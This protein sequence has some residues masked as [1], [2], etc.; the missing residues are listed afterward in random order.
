MMALALLVAAGVFLPAHSTLY[1][2]A[3]PP[4]VFQHDATVTL[5]FA[6]QAQIDASCQILFG[7]AP[8]GLRTNACTTK[9]DLIMPNPCGYP[10]SDPYAHLLCH[11]LGHANGWPPTHGDFAAEPQRRSD[12]SATD[13]RPSAKCPPSPANDALGEAC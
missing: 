12:Q 10:D 4:A 2:D 11:E 1:S 13:S 5:R 9:Q 8:A 6:G 7:K 3:R